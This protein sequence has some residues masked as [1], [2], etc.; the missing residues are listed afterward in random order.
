MTAAQQWRDALARWAIPDDILAAAPVS[1]WGFSVAGFADRAARQRE[2]PTP[3]HARAREAL[4]DGGSVLDVGC[5]GGAATLPLIPPATHAIGVDQTDGML[6][7]Y[8]A[9]VVE[10]G[11]DVTTVAGRWPDVAGQTPTADVVVCQDVFYNVP[12]LDD[13]V[14]ALTQHARHRVVAVLPASHP[15]TWTAP[16]WKALHGIGRPTDPT[17]DDAVA[18]IEETGAVVQRERFTEPTLWQHTDMDEAV[19]HVRVRL[20]L[21]ESRDAE[22][23]E[24]LARHP[25]PVEREAW[26]LW[27]PGS[28]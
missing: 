12:D 13:F 24:L 27:W 8:A 5:G 21:P 4:P 18:V 14:A 6:E 7:T 15:M 16:L 19:V 10:A 2:R 28:G 26:V 20:C 3:G 17:V 23:R 1:P 11:A 25:L 9:A 22:I